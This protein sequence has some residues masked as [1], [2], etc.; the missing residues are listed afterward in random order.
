MAIVMAANVTVGWADGRMG[1][2]AGQAGEGLN[3]G[4]G[5]VGKGEE[6]VC[7]IGDYHLE[8]E[9]IWLTDG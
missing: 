3:L 8:R 9:E 1:G 7:G 5:C 4:E 2:W 6:K